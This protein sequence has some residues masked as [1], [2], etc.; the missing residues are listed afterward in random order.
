MNTQAVNDNE[1]VAK[2]FV[3]Q[4]HQ[5]NERSRQ[6]LGLEFYDESSD[7][8]KN[9]QDSDFNDKKLP[10]LDSITVNRGPT[11]DNEV[12]IKKFVDDKIESGTILRSNQTLEKFLDVS[13][14]DDTYSLTKYDKIQITDITILRNVN[15]GSSVLPYRKIV[16]ND[17]NNIAKISN[18]KKTTKTN[19]PTCQ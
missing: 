16:C 2:A 1:V 9:N 11:L 19:S 7:L 17:K 15:S 12:T 5:Q 6:D 3:D 4:F 8:V 13:V 14:G 18:F 10:N